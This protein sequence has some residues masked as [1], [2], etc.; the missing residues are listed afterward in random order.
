VISSDSPDVGGRK[1]D[2]KRNLELSRDERNLMVLLNMSGLA[3]LINNSSA[4][5]QLTT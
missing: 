1:A 5:F 3:G 2:A 4:I